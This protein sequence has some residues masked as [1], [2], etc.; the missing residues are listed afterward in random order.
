M[1]KIL[2]L[3][4]LFLF[5]LNLNPSHSLPSMKFLDQTQLVELHNLNVEDKDEH[6]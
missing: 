1:K 4:F 5:H 6:T 2:K 3:F